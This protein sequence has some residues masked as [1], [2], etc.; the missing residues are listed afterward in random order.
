M[1][2]GATLG[3]ALGTRHSALGAREIV[4]VVVRT[5][6]RSLIVGGVVGLALALAAG[7][8]LAAALS[9]YRTDSLDLMVLAG[10]V[11]ILVGATAAAMFAPARRALRVDPLVTLRQ[12]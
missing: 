11:A 1:S 7:K 2:R 12:E 9:L 4:R 6:A 3:S 10:V 5:G 8:G